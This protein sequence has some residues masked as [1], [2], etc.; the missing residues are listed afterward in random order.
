MIWA[1]CFLWQNEVVIY[2]C[3]FIMWIKRNS[4]CIK[5]ENQITHCDAYKHKVSN[6]FEKETGLN[7][8]QFKSHSGQAD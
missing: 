6:I 5:E 2:F 4:D 3:I 1:I 7:L 8:L